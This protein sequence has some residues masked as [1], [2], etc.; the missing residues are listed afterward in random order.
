M[1]FSAS[2]RLA[3]PNDEPSDVV[4]RLAA[5]FVECHVLS[6]L[7]SLRFVNVETSRVRLVRYHVR[8][9]TVTSC[10]L[11]GSQRAVSISRRFLR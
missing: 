5:S 8:V 7:P 1:L 11:F 9:A 10:I 6:W 2:R 3:W 4:S